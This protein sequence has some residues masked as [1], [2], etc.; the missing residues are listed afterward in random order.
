MEWKLEKSS[1]PHTLAF[2]AK[3]VSW[4]KLEKL[5]KADDPSPFPALSQIEV[6][7]RNVL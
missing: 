7:G 5:I 4:V 1:L 2:K 6:Y 3:K